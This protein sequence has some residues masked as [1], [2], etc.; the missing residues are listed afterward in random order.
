MSSQPSTLPGGIWPPPASCLREQVSHLWKPTWAPL[1]GWLPYQQFPASHPYLL[2]APNPH[3]W[4][5]CGPHILR[6]PV[7]SWDSVSICSDSVSAL[8][9]K[10]LEKT[11]PPARPGPP[12]NL[13]GSCRHQGHHPEQGRRP[14][15]TGLCSAISDS[16][17]SW[18]LLKSTLGHSHDTRVFPDGLVVKNPPATQERQ[19]TQGPSLIQKDLLE[20]EMQPTPEFLPGKFHGQRS[21][22]G[23]SPWGCKESDSTS[24]WA[25]RPTQDAWALPRPL[26]TSP[27]PLLTLLP[28]LRLP[29]PAL[30]LWIWKHCLEHELGEAGSTEPESTLSHFKSWL[31]LRPQAQERNS[32]RK[33]KKKRK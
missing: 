19:E 5:P 21:P 9:A 4:S 20:K 22:A 10:I 12:K 32:E 17:T 28:E 24:Y 16:R 26:I 23:C 3:H 31:F 1:P 8:E 6:S 14:S 11:N 15:P 30:C 25:R 7:P 2:P 27:L 29:L 18:R 13:V 33:L